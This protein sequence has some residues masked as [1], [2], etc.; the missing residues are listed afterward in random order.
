MADPRRRR[1]AGGE[2]PGQGETVQCRD[3]CLTRHPEVIMKVSSMSV[4]PEG[5]DSPRTARPGPRGAGPSSTSPGTQRPRRGPGRHLRRA[6]G[7]LGEVRLTTSTTVPSATTI[8]ASVMPSCFEIAR[9]GLHRF[10]TGLRLG[11]GLLGEPLPKHREDQVFDQTGKLRF[12]ALDPRP[13]AV[14]EET[15]RWLA[16]VGCDEVP[17]A[18]LVSRAWRPAPVRPSSRTTGASSCSTPR[19]AA[20]HII[21]RPMRQG[22]SQPRRGKT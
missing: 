20:S 7:V 19:T 18:A 16:T 14:V 2:T 5:D 3:R 11:D 10:S 9:F 8:G 6:C 13:P 1:P 21:R 17:A 4:R 15:T 12:V 22:K